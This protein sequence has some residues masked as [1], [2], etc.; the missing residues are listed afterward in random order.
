MQHGPCRQLRPCPARCPRQS[1]PPSQAESQPESNCSPESICSRERGSV[2]YVLSRARQLR[3]PD[4]YSGGDHRPVPG[5]LRVQTST[6][7][8]TCRRPT[9]SARTVIRAPACTPIKIT[10]TN[11]GAQFGFF[12]NVAIPYGTSEWIFQGDKATNGDPVTYF[13]SAAAGRHVPICPG[14]TLSE[15]NVRDWS[16]LV[17]SAA[18][19][20]RRIATGCAR[21]AAVGFGPIPTV[22]VSAVATASHAV[23][24]ASSRLLQR[25]AE[26]GLQ[27]SVTRWFVGRD[28]GSRSLRPTQ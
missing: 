17:R 6:R 12:N 16:R 11:V 27:I 19:P 3:T 7:R 23:T 24:D 18:R 15:R 5:G 4:S 1:F 2:S 22:N 8:W 10:F 28:I 9:P 14:Q 21:S 20:R 26:S 13:H 25:S